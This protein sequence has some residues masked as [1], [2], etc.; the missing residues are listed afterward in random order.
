MTNFFVLTMYNLYIPRKGRKKMEQEVYADLL[1]LINFSMDYLC[2]YICAKVLHRPRS[3]PR[4]LIAAAV[5]GIYSIVALF[6]PFSPILDLLTDA[7]VCIGISAI[8]FSQKGRR[9]SSTLLCAFLFVGISMMTGGC[10]TAIFN[11]LNRLD[12]PIANLDTD[13]VS[14]YL[15]AIIAAAAGFISLRSSAIMSKKSSIKECLLTVTLNQKS[16]TVTAI[17][18]T[19]NLVKDP[20]SGKRIV[21]IDRREL[22]KIADVSE[23]D[24][25]ANGIVREEP[26][27]RSFRLVPIK[28]ASGRSLLSAALPDSL[29]A[30]VTTK[31]GKSATLSLDALIAPTN[32]ENSADGAMAVIP[33]EIIRI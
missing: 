7:V 12:L 17:A 27:I 28:T 1:F 5:G 14:T 4:M 33:A 24:D 13:G 21:L 11:L 29:T 10:M 2:L 18:D 6:L 23:F 19:G 32:I 26:T 3:L 9:F 15:F 8:A 25:F 20:L 22:D 30:S 16:V 31:K